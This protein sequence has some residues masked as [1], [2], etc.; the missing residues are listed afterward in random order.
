MIGSIAVLLLAAAPGTPK[1]VH[2]PRIEMPD[3]DFDAPDFDVPMPSIDLG[4]LLGPQFDLPSFRDFAR[5]RSD[6]REMFGNGVLAM[7][8]EDEGDDEDEEDSDHDAEQRRKDERQWYRDWAR[9]RFRGEDEDSGEKPTAKAEGTDGSA[10]LAVKAPVTFQLRLQAGEAEVVATDKSQVAVSLHGVPKPRGLQL[11]QYGDRVEAR[12][13]GSSQLRHGAIRVELP[14]GSGLDF[15][16]TSGDLTVEN[17]GGDVR[18]RTMSGDVKVKG[19]RNADVQSISGDV[20]VGITGPRLRLHV[21]SGNAVATTAD[22]AVQLNFESASGNLEWSGVCAKGC[23]LSTQTVSGQIKLQPDSSKSSFQ[24]SYASHSGDLR[25][26]L[27][28]QV[29]RAPKKKYAGNGGWL[30]AVYG[31]GEGVIECDAFSGDVILSK[32]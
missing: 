18:V 23:H 20:K 2:V 10:T 6:F 28:L 29:T 9:G 5:F 22:P 31:K 7:T 12:I 16:S 11:R 27:K 25:D 24:L 32:K 1:H 19:A 13:A 17:I 8:G 26:D 15:A 21:V 14:K 3:F 4:D 30:E